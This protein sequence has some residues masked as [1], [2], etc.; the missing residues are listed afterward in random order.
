[1][2]LSGDLNADAVAEHFDALN[3]AAKPVG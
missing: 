1:M 3:S 2:A